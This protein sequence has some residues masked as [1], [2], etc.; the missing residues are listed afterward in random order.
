MLF[1]EEI[2]QYLDTL[3]FKH[4]GSEWYYSKKDYI[5]LRLWVNS[6]IDFYKYQPVDNE[7][8]LV[9]RGKINSI[10]DIEWVFEHCFSHK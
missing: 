4:I 6:E 8:E 3:G 1:D 5:K 10:Q 2:K 9:F 7:K